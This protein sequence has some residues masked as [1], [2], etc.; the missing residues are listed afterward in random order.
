MHVERF[1]CVMQIFNY[2]ICLFICIYKLSLQFILNIKLISY[3]VSVVVVLEI[4]LM[5]LTLNH[6]Q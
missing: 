2:G 5:L 6:V 3:T 4:S 1:S